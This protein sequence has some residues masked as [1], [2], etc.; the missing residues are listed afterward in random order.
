MAG[1][2]SGMADNDWVASLLIGLIW[3]KHI[4]DTKTNI[5]RNG[6]SIHL[7]DENRH[8]MQPAPRKTLSEA[9]LYC[10]NFVCGGV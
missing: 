1:K 7:S 4:A 3:G 5:L 6:L 2:L 9:P 8:T 10:G